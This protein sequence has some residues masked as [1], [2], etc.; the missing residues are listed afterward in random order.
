M[1]SYLAVAI[2]VY[3]RATICHV[4]SSDPVDGSTTT[5]VFP[6][7]V[8]QS[9]FLWLPLT[10]RWM[11]TQTRY[12]PADVAST[13]VASRTPSERGLASDGIDVCVPR[14]GPWE[15]VRKS[16][17]L[18][19]SLRARLL[20][21]T[22]ARTGAHLVHSHFGDQGWEDLRP[23]RR[24]GCAHVVTFYGSDVGWLPRSAPRWMERYRELFDG[25]DRVLCEGPFMASTIAALGCPT[26]KLRV[27]HLGV[28]L[29]RIPF[30]PR[31]WSRAE[32]LRVLM[33]ASFVEKKGLPCGVRA[34]A[35]IAR[36]TPL[37]ITL[38]GD[39]NGTPEADAEK[40]AILSALAEE[41]LSPRARLLGYQSNEALHRE[42]AAHHLFL[43]PSVTA[44]NGDCEGGA[45]VSL[46]EMAASGLPLVATTHCDIPEVVLDG[47]TG[48]LAPER[49]V[50]ALVAATR[51]WIDHP[52]SW[53]E[54]LV[55]GR[56]HVEIEYDAER[57]GER[58]A[59]IYRNAV[60]ERLPA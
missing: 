30:E 14:I 4:T 18:T 52:D 56:R 9:A 2:G 51:R 58:L 12:L 60:A 57:Q 42:A 25:V 8:I 11:W 24:I 54:I 44:R 48:W 5:R 19:R 38:I 36:S 32:P 35:R 27:Q 46:I 45:P 55:A 22:A 1:N 20:E 53:S 37:E 50:E 21:R 43:Q 31:R 26:E 34:L 59:A 29:D 7:Q 39:S 47:R 17:R 13:V 41:G 28:E 16:R 23:V 10:Q 15:P 40:A 6:M 33:A 49:D 3:S